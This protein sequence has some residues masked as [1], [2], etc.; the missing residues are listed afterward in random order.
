MSSTNNTSSVVANN[1]LQ[2][3]VRNAMATALATQHRPGTPL[4][5][6]AAISSPGF[7]PVHIT[8]IARETITTATFTD[9]T[10]SVTPDRR[11]VVIT[12]NDGNT[13]V[14][15]VRNMDPRILEALNIHS[16][17]SH[18]RR[19]QIDA[20]IE[21]TRGLT[22]T[23]EEEIN[24]NKILYGTP[25][26]EGTRTPTNTIDPEVIRHSDTEFDP[27]RIPVDVDETRR[28]L[29]ELEGRG[30]E[31]EEAEMEALKREVQ[32]AQARLKLVG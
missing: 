16:P 5:T 12:N 21:D 20:I 8:Q 28:V 27:N 9:G 3:I 7:G 23:I 6:P 29:A 2:N 24:Y 26:P 19:R 30:A 31:L 1:D 25:E 15:N 11:Q 4:P 14:A 13:A 18:S 32:K 17:G 10:V 22:P